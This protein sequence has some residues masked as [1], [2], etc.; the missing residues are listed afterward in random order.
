ML[1]RALGVVAAVT[2]TVTGATAGPAA[3]AAPTIT[4]IPIDFTIPGE[5]LSDEC[6]V[7]VTT[8]FEGHVTIRE[9]ER[10][11]VGPTFVATV[12]ITVTATAG[13]NAVRI[14]NVGADVQRTTPDGETLLITGQA[15][16]A[17]KGSALIDLV[18]GEVLREPR[19]L[20]QQQLDEVCAALTA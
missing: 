14:K 9:F 1:S 15:P 13:D 12:N 20:S 5:F 6:G 4:R 16:F 11:G 8:R 18:T 2:L 19:D 7:K 3:A 10:D 17:F